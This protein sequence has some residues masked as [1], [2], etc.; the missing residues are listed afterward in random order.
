MLPSSF[1]P[2]LISTETLIPSATTG[3]S[4][5]F[6]MST[7]FSLLFPFSSRRQRSSSY[8]FLL[9]AADSTHA[10]CFSSPPATT[11]LLPLQRTPSPLFILSLAWTLSTS[12]TFSPSLTEKVLRFCRSFFLFFTRGY[13]YFFFSLFLPMTWRLRQCLLLLLSK[14]LAPMSTFSFRVISCRF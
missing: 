7:D 12:L 2:T 1:L 6:L 8:Y 14:L 11:F 10:W 5:S 4:H 3:I 13:I 9:P